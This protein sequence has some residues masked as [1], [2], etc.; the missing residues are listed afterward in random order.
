MKL[1]IKAKVFSIHDK[2]EVLDENDEVAY[3]VSSK[4]LSI[5]DKTRIEDA[6]GNEI[7]FVHAKA[8]S[9]HHVYY[10]EMADGTGFTMKEELAH[11]RDY[12]DVEEL[13]WQLRGES[14]LAFDF[15]VYDA[16]GH[17]LATAHRKFAS[18]H[19]MYFIDI[20]DESRADELV[21]LFVVVKH[22]I[23]H[24]EDVSTTPSSTSAPSGD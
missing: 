10:V 15:D 16:N 7:A 14:V 9:I 24:R 4:A 5:H 20:V 11:L 17:L 21:A 3:R 13:G 1:H 19:G 23:D 12:I 6:A 18:M 22:I 8:V 2:M